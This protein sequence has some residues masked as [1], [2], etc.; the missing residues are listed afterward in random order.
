VALPS[1]LLL[2]PAPRGGENS[3]RGWWG[4]WVD[5]FVAC[6]YMHGSIGSLSLSTVSLINCVKLKIMIL[7]R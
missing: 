6:I 4:E 5:I 7:L 2:R 1:F 3:E